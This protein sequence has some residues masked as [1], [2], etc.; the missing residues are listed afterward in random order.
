M[1]WNDKIFLRS[2][3]FG[4]FRE[5]RFLFYLL[6]RELLASVF[7]TIRFLWFS[8]LFHCCQLFL[9][10]INASLK[11]IKILIYL[12]KCLQT[13]KIPH[14]K[15]PYVH[16]VITQESPAIMSINLFLH[17]W[18]FHLTIIC[19]LLDKQIWMLLK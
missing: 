14:F 19:K 11:A 6:S 16:E 1:R 8:R 9:C 17:Y 7:Y 13:A 10:F 15:L 4:E 5:F 2:Y 18:L 12:S 3:F